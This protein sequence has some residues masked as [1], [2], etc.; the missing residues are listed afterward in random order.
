MASPPHHLFCFVPSPPHFPRFSEDTSSS[1]AWRGRAL[2]RVSGQILHTKVQGKEEK[3][4][5]FHLLKGQ[6][7][8]GEHL[9]DPGALSP[10]T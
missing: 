6:G 5:Y 2:L 7:E 3:A 10:L 4:R 8:W 9:P 1:Q